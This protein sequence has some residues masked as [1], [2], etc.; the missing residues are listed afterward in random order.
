MTDRR[1]QGDSRYRLG[2]ALLRAWA[3]KWIEVT[4]AWG[5]PRETIEH[6]AIYGSRST[7]PGRLTRPEQDAV[8]LSLEK[9]VHGVVREL[10]DEI[11]SVVAARYLEKMGYAEISRTL[12]VSKEVVRDRLFIA[13]MEV[14]RR[15]REAA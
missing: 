11:Q 5:Y 9:T 3:D 14:A 13:V 1:K 4:Q 2:D 10:P 15:Q 6:A 8:S 12:K 7:K